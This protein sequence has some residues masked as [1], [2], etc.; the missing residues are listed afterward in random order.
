LVPFS[1]YVNILKLRKPNNQ[2]II[3]FHNMREDTCTC[4]S[5]TNMVIFHK[6]YNAKKEPKV[7]K[8]MQ[9]QNCFK[10]SFKNAMQKFKVATNVFNLQIIFPQ[11]NPNAF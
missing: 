6:K 11:K 1:K 7:N 4:K 8:N 2:I 5:F 10:M 9:V 3:I